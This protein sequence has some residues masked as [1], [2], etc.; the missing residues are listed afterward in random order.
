MYAFQL[1]NHY[2]PPNSKLATM[3]YKKLTVIEK[4]FQD[5]GIALREQALLRLKDFNARAISNLHNL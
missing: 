3:E 2:I 5:K 1:H 4:W